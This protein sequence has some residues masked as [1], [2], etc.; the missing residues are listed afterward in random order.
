MRVATAWLIVLT[1][2]LCG[3]API[4]LMMALQTGRAPYAFGAP[5]AFSRQECAGPPNL[6]CGPRHSGS[7]GSAAS[8][9]PSPR[10]PPVPGS[11]CPR[12]RPHR[13]GSRQSCFHVTSTTLP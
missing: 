1:G 9:S 2:I 6:P 11:A 13:R 3:S 12:T 7:R 8:R 4:A 10:S 5:A